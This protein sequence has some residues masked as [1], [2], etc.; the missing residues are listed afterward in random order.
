VA[1]PSPGPPAIAAPDLA[2]PAAPPT[3]HPSGAR[4]VL[5]VNALDARG[6]HALARFLAEAKAGGTRLT[7]VF[8]GGPPHVAL[9][10]EHTYVLPKSTRAVGVVRLALI[11]RRE[12]PDN[13]TWWSPRSSRFAA[14][15][16]SVAGMRGRLVDRSR[17]PLG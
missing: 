10:A 5:V 17:R 14:A 8:H 15:A 3:G 6:D 9:D 13:L 16:A 2:E 12:D 1:P 11:L 7:V 4:E